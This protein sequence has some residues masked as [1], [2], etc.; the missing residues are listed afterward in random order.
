MC[1]KSFLNVHMQSRLLLWPKPSLMSLCVCEQ[2][3][4][5]CD[6]AHMHARLRRYCLHMRLVH[7]LTS[8][9]ERYS[10]KT[11]SQVAIIC[12]ILEP[13]T[14]MNEVLKSMTYPEHFKIGLFLL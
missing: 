6:C 3:T 10:Y 5:W 4:L 8:H 14:V 7:V 9:D 12:G 13:K 11:D 2:Q 1:K